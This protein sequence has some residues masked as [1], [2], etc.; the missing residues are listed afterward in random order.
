MEEGLWPSGPSLTDTHKQVSKG[1]L[2]LC[3]LGGW[4]V[5]SGEKAVGGGG[6]GSLQSHPK[7]VGLPRGV[8]R[9]PIQLSWGQHSKVD[10]NQ[11]AQ[12]GEKSRWLFLVAHNLL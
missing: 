5:L 7:L 4:A 2:S 9:D 11:R 10:L 6:S 12:S 3:Y 8:Y 1:R